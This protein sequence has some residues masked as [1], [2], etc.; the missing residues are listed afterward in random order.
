MTNQPRVLRMLTWRGHSPNSAACTAA[1][2]RAPL[3]TLSGCEIWSMH[4]HVI[5]ST[6]WRPPRS[7]VSVSIYVEP[8]HA[9][10]DMP[11][12]REV[13]IRMSRQCG[14]PP[15]FGG[16]DSTGRADSTHLQVHLPWPFLAMNAAEDFQ[17]SS[18]TGLTAKL[19]AKLAEIEAV[20]TKA[21]SAKATAASLQAV[22]PPAAS[23]MHDAA[24][25][26]SLCVLL[27]ACGGRRSCTARPAGGQGLGSCAV[28]MDS[29]SA[30]ACSLSW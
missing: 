2:A 3:V 20:A 10:T 22:R 27:L 19:V 14:R 11:L 6:R 12:V 29:S 1:R 17:L 5:C 9:C 25:M 8:R 30:W 16:R 7:S 28:I 21:Q 13:G 18:V 24:M 26:M 23:Q 4:G 15:R